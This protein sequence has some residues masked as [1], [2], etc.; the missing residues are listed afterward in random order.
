MSLT[1]LKEIKV[2]FHDT[3]YIQINAK[4]N[5][6]LS[7]FVLVS[8]YN[9]G[10]PY[11][12]T[13]EN[14]YAY[15]R[16]RKPD[17]LG[18]FNTCEITDDGKIL[19][20]LTEQMLAEVGRCYADLVILDISEY[21]AISATVP[22][23]EAE[24]AMLNTS[25]ILSTKL[26]G[27]NV[28]ESAIDNSDIT[29]SYEYNALNDLLVKAN[30]EYTYVITEA[31]RAEA[32]AKASEEAAKESE[33]KAKA[34]EEAALVS[35]QKALASEKA[36]K[37][38]E[39]A[40]LVSELNADESEAKALAS[41]QKA[42]QSELNAKNSENAA[43][44]SVLESA[45][46]VLLA[47]SYVNGDTGVREGEDEDNA[48][49]YYTHTKN[50]VESIGGN[51]VPMGTITSDK[52]SSVEVNTGYTFQITDAFVTDDTFKCGAGIKVPAGA[53][54]YMTADGKWDFSAGRYVTDEDFKMILETIE[55]FKIRIEELEAPTMI[56]ITEETVEKT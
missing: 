20:E 9:E 51:F 7:R 3:R 46:N 31:K 26:I 17:N 15:I 47:K 52:L 22:F 33:L 12:I 23:E 6:R 4:Q 55:N 2:D 18:V 49:F 1:I 30:A 45:N 24:D 32:A 16:F 38:S 39:D 37:E 5:D 48:L 27:F 14:N 11:P 28:I 56:A 50:V 25:K 43:A 42:L 35:E 29:S 41:E 8:C 10:S 34:S 40:A 36:A 19:I 13:V 53:N 21:N 54:V 44:Q